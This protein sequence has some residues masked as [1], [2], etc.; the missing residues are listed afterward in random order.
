VHSELLLAVSRLA[1]QLVGDGIA[2]LLLVE[3]MLKITKQSVND[4]VELYNDCP[5]CLIKTMVKD[6]TRLKTTDADRSITEPVGLQTEIDKMIASVR[7][8]RAFARPSG[9]EDVVRIFSEAT[10]AE[11]ATK[12]AADISAVI[13]RYGI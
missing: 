8:G 2:D 6:R 10:I 4:W 13:A 12:L 9:T 11:D 7:G 5:S 1:N 3:A